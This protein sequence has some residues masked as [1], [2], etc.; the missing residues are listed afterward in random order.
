MIIDIHVHTRGGS[1]DSIMSAADASARATEMGLDGVVFSEHS[2][3]WTPEE[4]NAFGARE[5]STDCGHIIVIGD[6]PVKHN[7]SALEIREHLD[8]TDG[9]M[10]L[11]HP[12]R[13]LRSGGNLL[14]SEVIKHS[15]IASLAEHPVFGLVDE[16][17]V[18]NGGCTDHE[19]ELARQVA[20]YVGMCGMAGSDAHAPGE[21]G[22]CA[23]A[24]TDPILSLESLIEAVRRRRF[25][26]VQRRRSGHFFA[27]GEEA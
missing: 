3:S 1:F 17:E 20:R 24:F 7:P 9:V 11:A 16:I 18:L 4:H 25:V 2:R 26:A 27:P 8:K 14:Y 5:Y 12:F 19:N 22:H 13:Y 10:I 6:L 23:T 21:I 15:D